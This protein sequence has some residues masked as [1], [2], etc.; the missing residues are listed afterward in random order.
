MS[1]KDDEFDKF[2]KKFMKD[3]GAGPMLHNNIPDDELEEFM[4]GLIDSGILDDIRNGTAHSVG[5][6]DI[7]VLNPRTGAMATTEG[8]T[9]K[10]PD[11]DLSWLD[12]YL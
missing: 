11:S 12:K 5:I 4:Q 6:Q 2:M 1:A 7:T 8:K 9:K 10:D 3:F